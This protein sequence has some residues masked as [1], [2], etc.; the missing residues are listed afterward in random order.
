[1]DTIKIFYG[2]E[3]GNAEMVADDIAEALEAN[4]VGYD[5]VSM[6]DAG[7]DD[8]AGVATAV[9]ITSTYGEG[10]LPATTGPF[11]DAIL[12]GAPDLSGLRFAAFGLGDSTY[13]TYNNGIEVFSETLRSF[14]AVQLG[15]TG[16]HDATSGES[17]TDVSVTWTTEVLVPA[18][19]GASLNCPYLHP[20]T[21]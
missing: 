4:G 16:R 15:E 21:A 1:M 11:N 7:I 17:A 13:A 8:L 3:S 10:E 6:E 18:L 2:T 12:A 19:E 14:G 9:F 20:A 5:I